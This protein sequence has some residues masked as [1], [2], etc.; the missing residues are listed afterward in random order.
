MDRRRLA[1]IRSGDPGEGRVTVGSGYLVAP[2]LVLTAR[3]V[4]EDRAA[5][6][7]WP[8]ITVTVGHQRDGE[9]TRVRAEA[10]W[11]HPGGLDVALLRI[12]GEIDPPGSVRWGRPTGSAPLR[13]EG[14]GYPLAAKGETRDP[15][16]LRGD[17]PV[18]SGGQDRYV[19]DQGPAPTARTDGRNAWGGA[20]GA[21]IFCGGHLVGV[22]TQESHAYGARRLIAVPVASFAEDGGF[23]ALVEEHTGRAPALSAIGGRPPE[24]GP[25][26]DRSPVE[27]EL[28]T[29]LTPLFPQPGVRVDHARAL[30]RELGYETRGYEPTAADL[31]ALLMA[32][33]RALASLGGAVAGSGQETSRAALTRLFAWARAFDCGS[34]LSV[35]EYVSLTG[36][37]G[38]VCEK[39]PALLSRTAKEALR[40]AALPEILTRPRLGE[41]DIRA[42]VEGLEDLSD[43]VSGADGA[44]PVPA[45]L[46]LVEYVAAAVDDGLG[47]D[48]RTWS[49]KT[50][51]RLGVGSGALCERRADAARWAGRGASP[52]SR[53]VMELTREPA[54]GDDRY[55]VRILLVRDDGSRR[56]LKEAE[57]R[58]R[59]PQE[60]AGCLNEAVAAASQ[61][62]GQDEHVPWVTVVVDREGLGLAVDEWEPDALEDLILP[63]PIGAHY[64]LSLS[65]PELTERMAT[66]EGDQARRWRNG[67]A[68]VFVTSRAAGDA[69]QLQ[70]LLMTEHRD[71]ARVV[72]HGPAHER[73]AWALTCLALGVPVV[74]WDR[75]ARGHE[76]AERLESLAPAGDLDGLAERVRHFRS[77]SAARPAERRA[78]PSLV[79][80]PEGSLPRPERLRLSD[81][82][83]GSYAS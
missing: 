36:L 58:P 20:S 33:P 22:V 11:T 12:D 25:A 32:H 2:R 39:Q 18:L 78:R 55:A 16:H 83:R 62:P 19:L 77:G 66:R 40:Y 34:L 17:L 72:L 49:G 38:R 4:L 43:A 51:R 7:V 28:E 9:T 75:D 46:R 8:V 48:L 70:H 44:F 71:T 52:V 21:A 61:E 63:W 23:V 81:P 69:R 13:Y 47:D 82:R 14:L 54:A 65:C 64:R 1:L 59:T 30:A 60:V 5:G 31:V 73:R 56:V 53:I 26:A 76:D 50:A 67:R 68:S 6:E 57:S 41:D 80:E 45:L 27:R 3:H 29:L 74:L 37:L 42:V 79:W 24:A 35:N 10:V 15:E